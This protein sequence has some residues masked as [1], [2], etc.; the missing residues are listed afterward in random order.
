VNT[1][2]RCAT[3]CR[4][5]PRA[6]K[7]ARQAKPI[8]AR[9]KRNR[10]REQKKEPPGRIVTPADPYRGESALRRDA[11]VRLRF[12]L[13]APARST[14]PSIGTADRLLPIGRQNVDDSRP[15]PQTARVD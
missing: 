6:K 10:R 5:H 8:S 2:L 7:P 14:A 12:F 9:A 15:A 11:A 3:N 13:S 4:G 1:A